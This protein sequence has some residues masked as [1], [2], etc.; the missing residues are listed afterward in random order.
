MSLGVVKAGFE[1]AFVFFAGAAVLVFAGA[2]WVVVDVLGFVGLEAFWAAEVTGRMIPSN[3][4]KRNKD[5]EFFM[6]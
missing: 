3:R 2:F 1:A 6:E 5:A 4:T